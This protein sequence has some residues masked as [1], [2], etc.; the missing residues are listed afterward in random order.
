MTRLREGLA[1]SAV[2][3]W[4]ALWWAA[5]HFSWYSL[6]QPLS[7][8]SFAVPLAVAYVA[9]RL[10]P[11]RKV[12]G[13]PSTSFTATVAVL[14]AFFAYVCCVFAIGRLA[15]LIPELY[16]FGRMLIDFTLSSL[17]GW[18]VTWVV[19]LAS[20]LA[21]RRYAASMS[22]ASVL[23]RA[24]IGMAMFGALLIGCVLLSLYAR[25]HA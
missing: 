10:L 22:L 14:A 11:G 5:S 2:V 21:V 12:P 7:F 17:V 23:S 24:T 9:S 1:I 25:R 18:A 19:S 3:L 13:K 8:A 4:A 15:M 6:L 16:K 20:A